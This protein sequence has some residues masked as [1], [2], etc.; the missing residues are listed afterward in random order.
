MTARNDERIMSRLL[1][2]LATV[3]AA[4]IATD[5]YS[6]DR[7]PGRTIGYRCLEP[8]GVELKMLWK[9]RIAVNDVNRKWEEEDVRRRTGCQATSVQPRCGE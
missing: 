1:E 3:V 7:L 5:Q 4:W 6:L 8:V 9:E 2:R